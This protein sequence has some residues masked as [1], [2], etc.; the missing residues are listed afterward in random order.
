MNFNC[1]SGFKVSHLMWADDL[2][3]FALDPGSLQKLLD[4]LCEYAER[5]KLSFKIGNT[6][7]M[8]FNTSAR[9]LKCAC[10]FRLGDHEITPVRTCF[11]LGIQFSL[12][13]SFK[14]AIDLRRKKALRYNFPIKHILDTRALTTSTMLTL[15]IRTTSAT[16]KLA[17]Y[18]GRWRSYHSASDTISERA[19][20]CRE[21]STH[22]TLLYHTFQEQKELNLSWYH[23]WSSIVTVSCS[24]IA[25]PGFSPVQASSEH[26]HDTS[27]SHWSVELPSQPKMSFYVAVKRDFEEE[28]C[29]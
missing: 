10:R 8:V 17:D 12:N 21:T 22:L 25:K 6:S 24:T 18:L 26:L 11:Y 27:I 7:I 13:G 9:I 15:R 20:F 1:P 5:W 3:L 19:L 2:V 28:Q 23:T 4:C 14:E 16:V 29:V